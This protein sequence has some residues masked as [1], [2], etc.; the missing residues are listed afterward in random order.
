MTERV[1][2]ALR[3]R[4]IVALDVPNVDDA[5]ALAAT[6]ADSV[7]FYKIGME[8]VYGGGLELVERLVGRGKKIFLDLKLHDIPATVE[9][10]AAQV[11]RRGATF[12]TVHAYPQTMAAAKAGVA[13][14]GLEILGVTVMTS[15]DDKDL[16]D[17]GYA[18]G[19]RDLV[20]RRADQAVE[21]GIGG[22]VLSA[23]ELEAL[24]RQV[25]TRLLL[26]TPGIRPAGADKGDQKRVVTPGA[27]LKAGADHIVVGR[28]ITRASDPRAAADAIL[29]EMSASI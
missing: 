1:A 19:V 16:E 8:L 29:A 10:A 18:Y 22:L 5:E 7:S 3:D 2:I 15:Y 23:Q 11:A 26:V 20:A 21:A 9:R 14:T 27:A 17:A 6:L 13:D 25:G 28:P 12:L 24:R 4:L